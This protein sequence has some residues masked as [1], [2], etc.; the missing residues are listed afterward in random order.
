MLE[1][2][3]P[4]YHQL[5]DQIHEL[6]RAGTL[7][8]GDRVPSVRK[9]SNQQR[10]SVSTV[11]QAYQR[12]EDIGVIEARPQSG[13]YVRR[14]SAGVQEPEPSRPPKRALTVEVNEL[15]DTVLA[16]ATNPKVVAFGSACAARSSSISSACAACCRARA[17]RPQRTRPLW[18]AAGHGEAAPRGGA[19]RARMGMPHR[20]P[21]PRDHDRRIEAINLALRAV[22]RPG[23]WSR[24]S[25]RPST[26]SCRS[27]RASACALEIPT[28]PR[29]GNL[30][31]GA[32]AALAEH[33]VKAV[34]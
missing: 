3:A 9:L 12:L 30:A 17:P 27:C 6:I 7:R 4:L 8:A 19:P 29:S 13:Y 24:S 26:A 1:T 10:V 33:P 21:Q 31:R 18:P 34:L 32:R 28:H 23:T 20:P 11:L 5:A 25:R 15:T 14:L 16:H 2:T 22:T